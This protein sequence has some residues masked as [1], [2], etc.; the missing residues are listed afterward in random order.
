MAEGEFQAWKTAERV[1]KPC[2]RASVPVAG[3]ILK[4]AAEYPY[5]YFPSVKSRSLKR[6][7]DGG[8]IVIRE[9]E[10]PLLPEK[11]VLKLSQHIAVAEAEGE[12]KVTFTCHESMEAEWKGTIE[13]S[14][15]PMPEGETGTAMLEYVFNLE[16]MMP[17]DEAQ[18]ALLRAHAEDTLKSIADMADTVFFLCSD[19]IDQ[20][21]L[22]ENG[23]HVLHSVLD[24][25][26]RFEEIP[27]WLPLAAYGNDPAN[28]SE[29]YF[30]A[31]MEP[32]PAQVPVEG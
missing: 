19:K 31:K 17:C 27:S 2:L 13:I 5:V 22:P 9:V 18:E 25:A 16:S 4:D 23:A 20:L 26:K 15:T 30:A 21:L 14:A 6:S 32:P 10:L 12:V 11:G 29:A 28:P 7:P 1:L 24:V 8:K 3:L